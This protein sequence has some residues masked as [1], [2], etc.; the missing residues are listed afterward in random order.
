M[1]L[2]NNAEGGTSGTTVTVGNSGGTSGNAFSA[3]TG[4]GVAGSIQ[5]SNVQKAHGSLAYRFATRGTSEQEMV[6][7]D[8]G[9]GMTGS[10]YCRCYVY[11]TDI[12]TA[13][14]IQQWRVTTGGLV[15]GN[16]IL[17]SAGV[18]QLRNG[19]DTTT[20]WTG[21]TLTA[22]TWYRI[23][24]YIDPSG[25][26][27]QSTASLDI[28]AGDSTTQV[29]GGS[30]GDQIVANNG[31]ANT[32]VGYVRFGVT[33]S[34]I[35]AP[36]ATGFIYMDDLAA[37]QTTAFGPASTTQFSRPSADSVDGNWTN[38]L[39]TNTNLFASIDETPASD[40]DYIQSDLAPAA[41]STR[42]K[43]STVATPGAGTRTFRWRLA[44]NIT[45]GGQIDATARIYQGGG[46]VLGAGTLVQTFTRTNVDAVT[47]YSETLTGT[48]TDYSQ[49]Y[50]EF[51]ANQI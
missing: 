2:T 38:E 50:V 36:S 28:Y 45:G 23:E 43:L 33:T 15:L 13:T 46:N 10:C 20:V 27:A 44:K 25:S 48:V 34:V 21:P 14:R 26:L 19:A 6:E 16:I 4:P 22:A 49:L 1:A 30:S 39:G 7:W 42:I 40:T 8:N 3:V 32:N 31:P 37:F 35:N 18:V 17:T 9:A 12:A 24:S 51:A 41:S 5:F 29:T 47:T 11:F